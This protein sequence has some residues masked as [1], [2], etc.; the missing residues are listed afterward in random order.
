MARSVGDRQ[1]GKRQVNLLSAAIRARRLMAFVIVLALV[2]IA[3]VAWMW[4]AREQPPATLTVGA[5]PPRSD[6]YQLMRE[7]AEVVERHS[8]RVRLKVIATPDSSRNISLLNAGSVDLATIR[9]DTPVISNVRLVADLFPDF[10]QILVGPGSGINRINDL[11]GKRMA[12]PVFGTDEF[13]SFWVIGDHYDLSLTALTWQA[14]PLE[15]AAA[16]LLAGRIDAL[17]TVRSLRDRML[18]DLFEDAKLK[19]IGVRFLEIDQ[20]E[21][22]AVKRPFLAAG[23]VPKGTFGGDQPTPDRDKSTVVVERV[24]VSRNDVDTAAIAEL[25][26]ILFENRLD[27][28]IRFALASAIRQPDLSRGLNVPL[29]DGAAQFYTR[30]EPNFLQQNAEPLALMVTVFAMLLSGLYAIRTQFLSRQKNRMDVYNY[31]LLAIADSARAA[32]ADT[33]FAGLKTEM[34]RL[35]ETVVHELDTDEVTAEGFVAFSR[36]WE[37]VREI[38]NESRQ[39]LAGSSPPA[40]GKSRKVRGNE[41]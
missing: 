34:V 36:L 20:S 31:E 40:G 7:I 38:V 6:S 8:R 33:D 24:L 12:I 17:F 1:G 41:A 14:V 30:D 4:F 28:T 11:A 19:N 29:H 9:A 15:Q 37:S 2:G 5:G 25:T 32:T 18:L 13:R 35:L 39:E 3:F 23:R 10:F 27:L 26:R 16:D 21:A 22:I